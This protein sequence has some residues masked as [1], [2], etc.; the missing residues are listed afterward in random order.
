LAASNLALL[1]GNIGKESCGVYILPEKTNSQ[2]AIDMGAVP[3]FF[4][5]YV[6]VDKPGLGAMDMLEPDKLKA[7]Y[8]VGE[9]PLLTYSLTTVRKSL[10]ALSFLVVQ[11]MFMTP[12]AE[13]AD[14]VLPACSFVEKD[15][16]YTNLERRIQ[17]LKKILPCVGESR[18]DL[19]IFGEL[20]KRLGCEVTEGE[21]SH[22]DA[23]NTKRTTV[24]WKGKFIPVECEGIIAD[25]GLLL[26]S[27]PSHLYSGSFGAWSPTLL[28]IGEACCEIGIG[29]ASRLGIK[30]GDRVMVS[31]KNA[32]IELK[33]RLSHDVPD[34]VGVVHLYPTMNIMCLFGKEML[35]I[36]G[37]V[38]L[39][40]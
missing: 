35:P 32:R 2:G 7:M 17:G 5:G 39:L 15:G 30:D 24:D 11:D 20:C 33:A 18:S 22:K 26:V 1:T 25:D 12:T 6:P 36:N 28:E 4:Q 38:E 21:V 10:Y 31:S 34:G 40:S 3:G 29:E 13:M 37:N 16:T 9:N 23:E 19:E 8:I 14:V 27:A